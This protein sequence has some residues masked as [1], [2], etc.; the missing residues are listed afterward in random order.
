MDWPKWLFVTGWS[1]MD[2]H[3]TNV[4][5]NEVLQDFVAK[6]K[7]KKGGWSEQESKLQATNRQMKRIKLLDDFFS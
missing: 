3:M 6:G 2:D 4:E 7:A 5:I 1:M